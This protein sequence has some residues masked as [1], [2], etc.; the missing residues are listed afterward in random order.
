MAFWAAGAVQAVADMPADPDFTYTN[1]NV[2]DG[3]FS[4]QGSKS[5]TRFTVALVSWNDPNAFGVAKVAYVPDRD[6]IAR[7][8]VQPTSMIAVGCTS[9]GQAQR[10][11]LWA[12]LTSRLETEVVTFRVGHDGTLVS[13]GRIARIADARR[14]LSRQGGRIHSATTT[15]VTIDA[16]PGT[17]AV[18]STLT[19]TLPTGVTE[20][21]TI[22][23]ISGTALTVGTP[24]S[25][26]PLPE[27]MWVVET[28]TLVAQ[29][30]RILHIAEPKSSDADTSYTVT[31]LLHNASKFPAIDSGAAIVIPPTVRVD[32]GSLPAPGNV[33][34]SSFVVVGQVQS[35]NVLEITWSTTPGATKYLVRYRVGNG[36]WSAVQEVA[37]TYLQI[38]GVK[39]GDYVAEVAAANA[40][41]VSPYTISPT[42]TLADP[43]TLPTAIGTIQKV[44]SNAQP[45]FILNPN[46][47]DGLTNWV[48]DFTPGGWYE[49]TGPDSPNPQI[50]TYAVHAGASAP[51]NPGGVAT[52]ALRNLGF[53][54]TSPGE[55]FSVSVQIH[56]VGSPQGTANCRISWRD[57]AQNEI[58]VASGNMITRTGTSIANGVAPVGAVYAHAEIAV[59]G[60]TSNDYF[61]F[62]GLKGGFQEIVETIDDAN[63]TR[64][65]QSGD[66]GQIIRG[67]NTSGLTITIPTI[68]SAG[69]LNGTT[70]YALQATSAPVKFVGA[71]GVTFDPSDS[72]QT[73]AQGSLIAVKMIADDLWEAVG[74]LAYFF[75]ATSVQ[76]NP[77]ATSAQPVTLA[78]T[79]DKQVLKRIGGTLQWAP[80]VAGDVVVTP[81]GGIA[82]TSTQAAL[83][84]LDTKKVAVAALAESTPTAGA[85]LVGV[86]PSGGIASTS[87]DAALSE[88]DTKKATVP[89][90]ETFAI[91]AGAAD[92]LTATFT[93]A[94]TL[95]DGMQIKLRAAA[96]NATTTPTLAIGGGTARAITKQGNLALAAG[97]IKGAGHELLLRYVAATPR[98]ELLNPAVASGGGGGGGTVVSVVAGTGISVNNADP[99]KP[100]VSATGSA[101]AAG[102]FTYWR[103]L[104][105]TTGAALSNTNLFS[106]IAEVEMAESSGGANACTGGTPFASSAYAGNPASSA[107]DGIHTDTTHQWS[108]AYGS[109]PQWLGYQFPTAKAIKELRIYPV[110]TVSNRAPADFVV[111][112]SNDGRRWY[113][114][115]NFTP[116]NWA[117]NTANVFS[118]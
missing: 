34:V 101:A 52:T 86:K 43:S 56:N 58:S 33:T 20:T 89:G 84:E 61:T 71:A 66:T 97:D 59:Y 60:H 83:A 35:S 18:G 8:G 62:T 94:L 15:V 92:A 81:V 13:P 114:A 6:G 87:L 24:F 79:A 73:R 53:V 102:P 110:V 3:Q 19:V 10:V 82:S 106:N 88:L 85:T 77:N 93:P 16:V 107:F 4:Y 36:E 109:F 9:Q 95:V 74:D 115:G 113:D 46:F 29:T 75:P 55:S 68:A 117:D 51:Q 116:T 47:A 22:T 17:V 57:N 69:W 40:N 2:V 103:I 49:T 44:A 26:A 42:Y 38:P 65:A 25:V 30:F 108:S 78:A 41:T 72:Q 80:Q 67:T 21:Q 100:V 11:G 70:L 112:G 54:P 118:L 98:W 31:A 48:A 45:A 64:M 96:A 63:T 28:S 111:Q 1:A 32:G 99:T 12:L 7:Y 5:K 91:A 37:S 104:I 39:A 90:T 76:A 23:G 105:R 14:A 50:G 27:A